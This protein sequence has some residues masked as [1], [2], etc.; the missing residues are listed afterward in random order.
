MHNVDVNRMFGMV[1]F[2]KAGKEIRDKAA[3]KATTVRAKIKE[4]EERIKRIRK[5]YKIT[6]AVLVDLMAQAMNDRTA[7][8]YANTRPVRGRAATLTTVPAGVVT[9]ITTEQTAMESEREQ[10]TRLDLLARNVGLAAEHKLSFDELE[11]LGF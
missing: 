8:T 5:E 3:A 2:T 10:A 9:N 11:F 7:L 4:R 1:V 6:D